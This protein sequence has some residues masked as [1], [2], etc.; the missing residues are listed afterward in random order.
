V[1]KAETATARM[2]MEV[3][4]SILV[5]VG[6]EWEKPVRRSIRLVLDCEGRLNGLKTMAL[7]ATA[8]IGVHRVLPRSP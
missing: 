2:A 8:F 1:A 4:A 6:L 7:S 5:L 3:R